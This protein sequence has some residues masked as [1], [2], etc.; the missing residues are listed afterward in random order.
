MTFT[1]ES[2]I[3]ELKIAFHEITIDPNYK[4]QYH[5]L[6]DLRACVFTFTPAAL[7][8]LAHLLKERLGG[9]LGKTAVLINTPRETALAML[10]KDKMVGT[11]TIEL[12]STL[13]AALT[14]LKS[15]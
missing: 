13:E 5:V 15:D 2:T 4:P 6:G 11:R 12:F 7:N 10:H 1:G 8:E 9:S 14:W 3:D